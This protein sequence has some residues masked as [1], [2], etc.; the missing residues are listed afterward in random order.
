MGNETLGKR[1]RSSRKAIDLTLEQL[2]RLSGV[3]TGMISDLEQE[4]SKRS[5]KLHRLAHALGVNVNWL[6]S[7][8]GPRA[9][10]GDSG[11]AEPLNTY[12]AVQLSTEAAH[13]AQEWD[14][15]EE[16]ARTQLRIMVE[17]LVAAQVRAK[18]KGKGKGP[19]LRTATD[20]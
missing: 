3:S 1:L 16:P 15:L 11:V 17:G 12:H 19:D 2:S 4:R 18:R 20:A 14:K 5:T 9:A 7:G 10:K 13:F 8:T 6:E